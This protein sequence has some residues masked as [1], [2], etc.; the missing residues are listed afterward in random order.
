MIYFTKIGEIDQSDK[1]GLVLSKYA[2]LCK[3]EGGKVT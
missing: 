2:V 1:P 3:K